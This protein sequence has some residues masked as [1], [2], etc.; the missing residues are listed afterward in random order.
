[1]RRSSPLPGSIALILLVT[2]ATA[3]A[4]PAPPPAPPASAL[5]ITH[6]YGTT[7]VPSAPTR[8]VT[9]SG[10]DADAAVALGVV[11]I[12]VPQALGAAPGELP[13]WLA[14]PIGD[15]PTDVLEEV[16][17]NDG[18]KAL[19]FEAIAAARPDVILSMN[20]TIDS[21]EYATLSGIAPT[22]APVVGNNLD[23]WQDITKTVG[24]VL[25]KR[26]DAERLVVDVEAGVD[27][28]AAAHPA[29]R[30]HSIVVSLLLSQ[31]QFGLIVDPTESTLAL[32]DRLG[33]ALPTDVDTLE[34]THGFAAQLGRER[35]DLLEAD[36]ALAYAPRPGVLESYTSDPLVTRLDV[37]Q[38]GAIVPLD[39]LLWSAFRNPS[40]LTVPFAVD[41]VVALVEG[42]DMG[43]G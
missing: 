29:F 39:P 12:M 17:N 27:E 13:P 7:Q 5:S 37:A 21:N 31:D 33:F 2:A 23:S 18:R 28:V 11:P 15:R 22:V 3:C 10:A 42:V 14:E 40:V 36:V 19:P 6:M 1:V 25:G 38:R 4:N 20:Y 41:Q 43:R 35:V 24:D 34:P 8:V 32:M 16:G 26:A 9:L 30:G